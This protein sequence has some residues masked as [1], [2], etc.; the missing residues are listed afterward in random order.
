[1]KAMK[2]GKPPRKL[3]VPVTDALPEADVTREQPVAQQRQTH[4]VRHMQIVDAALR[5]IAERGVAAL[6]VNTL[7]AEL[8][9]TGGALYRHFASTEDILEAV[10]QHVVVLVQTTFPEDTLP[11]LAWLDEFVRRR[12]HVLAGHKGLVSLLLCEQLAQALPDKAARR[13]RSLIRRTFQ[14]LCATL[15]RGQH[16]GSIRNDVSAD[17]LAFLCMGVVQMTVLGQIGLV[18]GKAVPVQDAYGALRR[19]LVF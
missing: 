7:A 15:L 18:F 13:L 19:L 11:A 9:L 12:T 16:D 4:A 8:G 5:L 3:R 14:A 17:H 1:M 2:T 10:A 6:T